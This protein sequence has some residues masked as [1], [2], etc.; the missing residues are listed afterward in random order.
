MIHALMKKNPDIS[1]FE[2]T[3][4][5]EDEGQHLQSIYLPA[6]SFGGPGR[7]GFDPNSYMDE[8]HP[9]ASEEN[10]KKLYEQWIK[11]WDLSKTY[12]IEKSPPNLVRTRFLQRLFPNSS[13]IA[14]LRHPIA[15]AYA[16]QKWSRTSISSLIEH[17][18][19]CY[20]RF[21]SDLPFLNNVFVLRY[22]D[23]VKKPQRVLDEIFNFIGIPCISITSTVHEN[24]NEKYFVTW[25]K[26][27]LNSIDRWSFLRAIKQYETRLNVL[28]Y[29]FSNPK[30][31]LSVD[32]LGPHNKK[33]YSR[34]RGVESDWVTPFPCT[35]SQEGLL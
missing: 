12:L 34:R 18:C 17:T 16:T 10:G 29:S 25:A 14:V 13:F 7:F 9:L 22:E 32:F 20:E 5:S 3:G 11:Y 1:G 27:I 26:D 6:L 8:K 31:L 28:G 2:N 15:V 21:L 35:S 33:N 30:N 23:F 4:V 24:I 19:I